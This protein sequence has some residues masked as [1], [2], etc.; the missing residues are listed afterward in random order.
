MMTLRIGSVFYFL[1]KKEWY[2][3]CS[4][5]GGLRMDPAHPCDEVGGKGVWLKK[6]GMV[7]H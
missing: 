7:R 6:G 2:A 1:G 5:P 4:Q 3:T